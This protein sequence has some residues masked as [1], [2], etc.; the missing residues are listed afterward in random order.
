MIGS[1]GKVYKAWDTQN[2]IYVAL[3]VRERIAVL[4]LDFVFFMPF[5]RSRSFVIL[6]VFTLSLIHI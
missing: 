5:P 4:A 3:K 2:N 1:F 6:S